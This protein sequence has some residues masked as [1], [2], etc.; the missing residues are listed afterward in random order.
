MVLQLGDLTDIVSEANV[1]YGTLQMSGIVSTM[2]VFLLDRE[3]TQIV[4]AN[5]I[6]IYLR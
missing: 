6:T 5:G 4:D 1:E 2:P 3:V